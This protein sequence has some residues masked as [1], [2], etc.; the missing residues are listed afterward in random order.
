MG[1]VIKHIGAQWV[2]WI[3]A[4][5]NFC[6]FLFYLAIGDETIYN[7]DNEL[8]STGFFSKVIPRKISSHSLRV[9]D[10]V[11][12]FS[13]AKYPRVVIV[14]CAHAI[15]FCYANIALIVEMP[16]ATGEKFHFNPQQV[17]L[18][19]IAII[20]GCVLGEQISGPTSDWFLKR[21][22]QTREHS[23]PADR[24]WLSY[25]AFAMVFAGLL[26]WGFQLQHAATWNV[27][28]CI[29]AAIASFGNQMQT[30]I[31]T[32]FAVESKEE[33]SSEVGIFVNACRQVYG[34]VG[35]PENALYV[36]QI[37]T[38]CSSSLVP[39]ISLLCSQHWVL[40]E[41]PVSWLPLLAHAPCVRLSLFTLR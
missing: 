36:P 24:L 4:I 11:V 37:L 9:Q 32:T 17:G 30:T 28:P 41:L 8:N 1:F 6:Q 25:I 27:T 18:Q 31:L 2:F 26:V 16:I 20:I 12:P 7:P 33:R 35:H 14:A 13:L 21:V 19:F 15:T 39:S 23:C 22:R 29:G 40:M 34:F 3:F 5:I 38:C 10:I